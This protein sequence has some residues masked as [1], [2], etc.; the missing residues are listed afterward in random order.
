MQPHGEVF[1]VV[2]AAACDPLRELRD[3]RFGERVV[4][5]RLSREDLPHD[6]ERDGLQHC[7]LDDLLAGE[8][9]LV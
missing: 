1:D 6:V 7:L 5:R 2:P 8:L 4:H 3:E 9:R